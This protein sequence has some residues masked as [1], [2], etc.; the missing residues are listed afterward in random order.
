MIEGVLLVEK[1]EYM[2]EINEKTGRKEELKNNVN[3]IKKFIRNY[4]VNKQKYT[5]ENCKLVRLINHLKESNNRYLDRNQKINEVVEDIKL[6]QEELSVIKQDTIEAKEMVKKEKKELASMNKSVQTM[7][8]NISDITV[9][10]QHLILTY[11]ER[12]R[13]TYTMYI[14]ISKAHQSSKSKNTKYC[15]L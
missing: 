5:W 3:Y 12:K 4:Q 1:E 14:F 13:S 8:K 11:I 10:Y 15:T 9:S 7:N 2:K 6:I